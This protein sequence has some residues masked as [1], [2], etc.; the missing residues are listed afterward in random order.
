MAPPPR[1]RTEPFAPLPALQALTLAE[2][3]SMDADGQKRLLQGSPLRRAGAFGLARNAVYV[4]ARRARAGD[5]A[6]AQALQRALSHPDDR[7][8]ALAERLS[9]PASVA[10]ATEE[11]P[12]P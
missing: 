11:E 2:L 4:A 5:A 10:E 1:G 6:G 7:I 3:V 8:R 12:R 9:L